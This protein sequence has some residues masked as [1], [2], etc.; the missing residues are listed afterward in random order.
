MRLKM[1]ERRAVVEATGGRYRRS[2]KKEKGRILDEF[3][4]LTGYGRSYAR[5]VLRTH[6]R[7]VY[8]GR[9]VYIGRAGNGRGGPPVRR[10][11]RKKEYDDKVIEVLRQVWRIMDYICGKRLKP[12]LAEVAE[13][14]EECGEGRV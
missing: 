14:L 12:V 6:G 5:Y 3:V 8:D 9:R 11:A 1:A 7:V 2:S 4:A 10:A 13:R